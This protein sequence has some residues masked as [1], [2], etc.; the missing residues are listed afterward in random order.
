MSYH[1]R[2]VVCL[3][4]AIIC[5]LGF[6]G[7]AAADNGVT[8]SSLNFLAV[9]GGSSPAS[10]SFTIAPLSQSTM[11]TAATD[12]SPWL[13]ISTS[14]GTGSGTT[15]VSI[16]ASSLAAGSYSAIVNVSF[17][18][19]PR[20]PYAQAVFLNVAPSTVTLNGNVGGSPVTQT[21]QLSFVG[22]GSIT[23]VNWSATVNTTSGGSWLNVTPAQG[24]SPVGPGTM[25]VTATVTGLA[26][27]TYNGTISLSGAFFT[28]G[29]NTDTIVPVVLTVATPAVTLSPSKLSFTG[30]AGGA[31]PQAQA[32]QVTA[33]SGWTG[34]VSTTGTTNWLSISPTSGTGNGQFSVTADPSKLSASTTPYMGTITVSPTGTGSPVT[35]AVSFMVSAPAVS[36]APTSMT[37]NA[38]YGATPPQPQTV[39]VTATSGWSGSV[40]TNSGGNWLLISPVSGTSSGT[41][42]V[43]INSSILAGGQ[44]FNGTISVS[45][46]G[47]GTPITIPVTV[48]VAGPAI[49]VAPQS[50]TLT[51]VEGQVGQ[52]TT[53]SLAAVP[54]VSNW[55]ASVAVTNSTVQWLSVSPGG[56]AFPQAASIF[57]NAAAATLTAA[58]SPYSGTVTFADANSTPTTLS[59]QV[60]LNVTAA[61]AAK[62]TV[63]QQNITV[64]GS[65]ASG[66][67]PVTI[68]IGNSGSGSLGFSVGQAGG[69]ATPNGPMSVSVP[70]T[71]A[72]VHQPVSMVVSFASNQTPGV[73][74]GTLTVTAGTQSIPIAVTYIVT[75]SVPQLLLGQTALRFNMQ[76]Q[77]VV[78]QPQMVELA[79]S[80]A[81]AMSYTLKV[82]SGNF[83]ASLPTGPTTLAAGASGSFQVSLSPSINPPAGIS[84]GLINVTYAAASA[85]S[86]AL[87]AA[88]V[89]VLLD[90]A[91]ATA[92]ATVSV[93]PSAVILTPSNLSQS[94]SLSTTSATAVPFS[95]SVGAQTPKTSNWLTAVI[96]SPT[97]NPFTAVTIGGAASALPTTPGVYTGV[98]TAIFG[99]G[100]PSQDI[101]VFLIIPKTSAV[102]ARFRGGEPAA[103]CTPSQL[104]LA[105]R[106]LAGNFSSSVG[107]P[108]NIEA[109]L[110]DDCGNPV[111][112]ATVLASFSTGDSPL[113]LSNLGG[114]VYSATWNPSNANPATVTVTGIDPPLA[115]VTTAVPGTVA[116]NATPPPSISAAGVVNGASFGQNGTVSPGEI[117]SVFGS[118]LATAATGNSG[119]PLP[120]TLAG[121]KLSM[122]GTDMPLFFAG[123]GQVNAQVPT[124]LTPNS[125]TSLV[126]RAFSGSSET[127]DSVPVTVAVASVTPGI[128]IAAESSAPN[129]GAIL[130]NPAN[131]VVDATNPATA[132]DVITIYCTGLGATTPSVSTGA[133]NPAGSTNSPVTVTFG[134][135]APVAVQ[136]GG[137]A[138]GFIGLYQVNVTVPAGL[139]PGPT[140][141]VVLNQGGVTSNVATIAVH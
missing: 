115:M 27:G 99:N 24:P 50:L 121:I 76:A 20:S 87:G 80:G 1:S 21:L 77:G 52:G 40:T 47:G 5:T 36:V 57:P 19:D 33:A 81:A 91:P 55:A 79:N 133:Q 131:Q 65:Q 43:T 125:Q 84:Y 37:F 102:D 118:P 135:L 68:L 75:P 48:N 61:S 41:F 59:V 98:V 8:P 39:T 130:N 101:S 73:Y 140:V 42:S 138:P 71:G 109:Q 70:T 64:V 22:S 9:V 117:I 2:V 35:V 63:S 128:F 74:T 18:G 129:Q 106:Q 107:W 11:W 16:N 60:T 69:F 83:L 14:S 111:T 6:A 139:T 94:V 136:Y 7:R 17:V 126:A 120:T 86:V 127:G 92:P 28:G 46:S 90:V 122:G 78:A 26:V 62:L 10:Q 108:Q 51:Q 124:T 82:A 32:V 4:L 56:G 123:T 93:Y 95:V 119:L 110:A 104:V 53:V 25:T 113:A 132:G 72:T 89:T 12:G 112:S 34:S 103:S 105:L 116:A 30:F 49:S 31:M 15:A 13:S 97:L 67:S 134:T 141:S 23:S 38:S 45:A 44:T 100:I 66:A 96:A 85:P 54:A 137:L 3:A 29:N 58:G 114:G 88:Y